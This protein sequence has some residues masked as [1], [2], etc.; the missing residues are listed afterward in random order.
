[1]NLN[2]IFPWLSIRNKL[3]IAFA[4]LSILPLAFVG[5]YSIMT[6]VRMMREIAL[7][8]LTEDVQTIREKSEN[9]LDNIYTDLRVL[10]NSSFVE[11]WMEQAEMPHRHF[12]QTDLDHIGTE[13]LAFAKTK[14]MYYQFRLIGENGDE[15]LRIECNNPDDSLKSYR[16]IPPS[17]LRRGRE[18]YYFLLVH[19]VERNQIAF[20]PAE[21]LAGNA[22]RVP[23][24]SF[25]MPL[26]RNNRRVGILIANVFER[27]LIEA[28][29]NKNGPASTRKVVLAT[30]DG[31]YLYRSDM[32]KDWNRLLASRGE[33][34]LQ[35]DYPLGVVNSILSGKDGTITKG[36]SDIIS[37]A[38]LFG[39]GNPAH[40]FAMTSSFAVPIIVFES[41]S[42]NVVLGPVRTYALTYVAFLALFLASAVALGLI[43]TRQITRPIAALQRGAEIIAQG[44][45]GNALKVETHDEIEKLA[46]QF[47]IMA[48]SLRAHEQEIQRHRTQLEE[49]VRQRTLELQEEKGKLQAVLD[50]VPSAFVLLDKSFRIQTV[51]AAFAAVTGIALQDEYGSGEFRLVGNPSE[52]AQS[53][54]KRAV[55]TGEIE[56]FVQQ[57]NDEGKSPRYL[58]YV[59]IPMKEEGSVNAVIVIMTDI[60]KRK[61]LE[62]Q[63]VHTEKLMAAGEM[64]SIIAH[65]F[66]NA[67]TSVKM[68]VQ[69]FVESE[70]VT[71]TEK[72]S[73]AVALDSI[74]HMETIVTE[75]LNFARPKP[76]Q[77]LPGDL[78]R[79][80]Q[81]SVDFVGP[82]IQ[83]N[84]V[85][86][87][88]AL[89][90]KLKQ[91]P[92]DE[93]R[94]K[95]AVINL[96]LNSIQAQDDHGTG[97]KKCRIDI[98]TRQV[99]LK[100][101]IR[102]IV[103]AENVS[104]SRD[105]RRG[106]EI[107]LEK[108][109]DCALI[110]IRDNG[111][112]IGKDELRRIFDPFFTTKT[113]GT[114][115]GLPMVKR[116]VIAHGGVVT[117][118]STQGEGTTF[119]IYMPTK[120]AE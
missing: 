4:G 20:A 71:R 3:L 120:D 28:I 2:K 17:A 38:P 75:L 60:T 10:Q 86:V 80:V 45:Y 100:N 51:S 56:T 65:E 70:K 81:E 43:A 116:T 67:L 92:L 14:G 82:H 61:S 59:A 15:L 85:A 19:G 54:W 34:N 87:S 44:N 11:R 93:S 113:N 109:S 119:R 18:T 33:E 24:I 29:E 99:K 77:L 46:D 106:S 118:E 76:V 74:Y 58:E 101:T 98:A 79:I 55:A 50:N 69:L 49:M 117:V 42:A 63:L 35:R 27:T 37:Y 47:N 13:L 7:G 8:E 91:R 112:G 97:T 22:K 5:V 84:D 83:Q 96:L 78:N 115:L 108:N 110:E 88:I 57:L 104:E 66:R 105:T 12:P 26:E 89:D 16:V 6:N 36:M 64:S 1:M 68:I 25:A 114:G 41:E 30:G 94:L 48:S 31:H 111:K 72:K 102:D 103:Y 95:E 62:Q 90:R 21:L 107:V 23:V 73:L 52:S 39:R 32:Q 40:L 9:F 53:P